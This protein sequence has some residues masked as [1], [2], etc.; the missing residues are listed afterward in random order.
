MSNKIYTLDDFAKDILR[1]AIKQQYE[2]TDDELDAITA[3]YFA[4]P[5]P[6]YKRW[7]CKVIR[8]F[9]FSKRT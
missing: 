4:K 2:I 9:K 5:K 7:C 6:F 3:S 1:P 8:M